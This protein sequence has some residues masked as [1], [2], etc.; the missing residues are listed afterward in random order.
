MARVK[1]KD[2]EYNLRAGVK[3]KDL[4][5][6]ENLMSPSL[7]TCGGKGSCGRCVVGVKEMESEVDF[8]PVRSCIYVVNKDIEVLLPQAKT[9]FENISPD[10]NKVKRLGAAVDIGTTTLSIKFA[11]MNSGEE[12]G[13]LVISN[14]E[15]IYGADVVSRIEA[16]TN[17]EKIRET[18]LNFFTERF[19]NI[20]IDTIV[21]S[22]NTVMQ[23]IFAGASLDGMRC[24]PMQA[25]K[26]YKKTV[27]L[28]RSNIPELN[29]EHIMVLPYVGEYFGADALLGVIESEEKSEGKTFLIIDIGTNSEVALHHNGRILATAAAA[30]SAMLGEYKGSDTVAAVAEAVNAGDIDLTGRIVSGGEVKRRGVTLTQR[31]I[32]SYQLV[33]AAI[34]AGIRVLCLRAGIALE[35]VDKIY[36][37]GQFGSYS[38]GD[39]VSG[40]IIPIRQADI[41][42]LGNTSLSGAM[43]YLLGELNEK[44]LQSY[45]DRIEY[46]NMA[47]TPEFQDVFVEEISFHGSV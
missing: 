18:L 14:P 34:G 12:K 21:I 9:F 27:T 42:V 11:D 6:Q 23:H 33:K 29:T 10:I 38:A 43:K 13:L 22:A 41:E 25:D 30:G 17:G 15:A 20:K 32:R 1:V 7:F 47:E 28:R 46:Y 39:L 19:H 40:G 37:S 24:F 8:H 4:L 26:K 44:T 16:Y 3:L 36:V 5:L 45:I 2:K 31:D 35:E